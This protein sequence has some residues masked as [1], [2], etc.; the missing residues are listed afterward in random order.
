M[1]KQNFWSTSILTTLVLGLAACGGGTTEQTETAADNAVAE[2]GD[3]TYVKVA[4]AAEVDPTWSNEN[5]VVFHVI[6]EPDDMHP[7]NGN[8]AT[9]TFLH[10]YTQNYVMA[11]DIIKLDVRQM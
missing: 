7:T 6:G 2:A 8:S 4:D 10:N 11:S 1:N 9:K 3:L 5:T